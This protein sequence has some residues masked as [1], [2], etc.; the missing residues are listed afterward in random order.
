MVR[1]ARTRFAR[2]HLADRRIQALLKHSDSSLARSLVSEIAG[3]S[4][5][6]GR[7]SLNRNT[8]INR[9]PLLSVHRLLS[10]AARSEQLL[11][12][13]TAPYLPNGT[14]C[15][16]HKSIEPLQ[17]L[18]RCALSATDA[19]PPFSDT[20]CFV[21]MHCAGAIDGARPLNPFGDRRCRHRHHPD[22]KVLAPCCSDSQRLLDCAPLS[23]PL[24]GST[25]G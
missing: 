16:I 15:R 23:C 8:R 9:A 14:P 12:R 17:T 11:G 5:W 21:V 22:S 1:S 10:A 7:C 18:W 3:N 20:S 19:G 25:D 13:L 24:Q 6:R 4:F 2:V